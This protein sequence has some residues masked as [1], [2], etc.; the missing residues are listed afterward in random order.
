M[1]SESDKTIAVPA[2]N[3]KLYL[4]ATVVRYINMAQAS[5][6]QGNLNWDLKESVRQVEQKF[7]TDLKTIKG[8]LQTT[9]TIE[10]TSLSGKTDTRANT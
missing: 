1:S 3:F 10:K 5:E 9:K 8:K 4:R 2:I 6:I 7:A